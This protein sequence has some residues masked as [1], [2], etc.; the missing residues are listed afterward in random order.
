MQSPLTAA[1]R[2]R[3]IRR[4]LRTA[5]FDRSPFRGRSLAR[6][7][8]APGVRVAWQA[9]WTSRLV[10]LGS[11]VLAV[12]S[13]GRAPGS[14]AFDPLRLTAP[15]GYFGNLLVAPFAR[16]DSVWY[17]TIAHSGYDH[18]LARAEFF[19][20]YPLGMRWLGF[21]TGSD[22]VAGIL[23]SLVSFGVALVLLYRLAAL[24]LGAE[25][26]RAC[27]LVLAFCPM[28]WAFSAVYTEALFLALSLGS[29]LNARSGRWGWAGL[30]G[31]LAAATRAEGLTLIV[32]L[33]LMFLYG[34]R[35][36]R[37][38]LIRTGPIGRWV[39]GRDQTLAGRAR[40]VLLRMAPRFPI[41]RELGWVLLVPVG[42]GAFLLGLA[43][44]GADGLAPLHA[45]QVWFRHFAGPFGGIWDGAKAAWAGVRQLVHGP[46]PPVYFTVAAGNPLVVAEQNLVLFGF[47]VVALIALVGA[48]RRLPFAYGAYALV[49]LSLPLSYPVTPQPLQSISRYAMVIFPLFMWAGWWC[50]RRRITVPVVASLAVLLGLFTAEFATWRFVA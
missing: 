39:L 45:H 48:F 50:A 36:D 42:F 30:L 24:E 32:P 1:P 28:A 8:D 41:T 31:A 9:I 21:V 18:Q 49:A 19:P 4:A 40:L 12:L 46:A 27:V 43:L 29:V 25:A 23:I 37:A 15:F 10:V 47:L 44:S 17:L 3:A 22:L 26:A 20:L 38:P 14:Q 13:F 34:P 11:G 2:A 33:I 6:L 35:T 5:G 7:A 16:W